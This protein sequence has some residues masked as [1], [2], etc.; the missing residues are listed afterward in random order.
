MLNQKAPDFSLEASNGQ[1]IS[2]KDL[3]G[4]FVVL[5]FYPLTDSPTCNKQLADA[6]LNL[7]QFLA[8][9]AAVFGINTAPVEKQRAYCT[10]K[11]LS[12]PI[13]SDPGGKVAKLYKAHMLW[14]PFN[15]RTVVVVDPTG[16]ICYWKRGFPRADELI[17][18]IGSKSVELKV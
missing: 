18:A 5:I 1:Q 8:A 3:S 14:M 13:L 12:F 9:N 6:E 16:N 4:T 17:D 7:Q 2:L 10:R 11:R 15:L